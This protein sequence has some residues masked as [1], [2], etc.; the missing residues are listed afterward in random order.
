MPYE[1]QYACTFAFYHRTLYTWNLRELHHMISLR[2]KPQGH[3]SYRNIAKQCWEELNKI[4]PLL[5]KYIR[6]YQ[7]DDRAHT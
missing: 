5:A 7:G 4:H 2:S 1:A 6:V 3:W